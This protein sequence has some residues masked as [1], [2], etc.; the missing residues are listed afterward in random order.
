[1]KLV[2]FSRLYM[3]SRDWTSASHLH[4]KYFN[5]CVISTVPKLQGFS[6]DNSNAEAEL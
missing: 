3:G 6:G 2:L 1:M 5:H 4:R